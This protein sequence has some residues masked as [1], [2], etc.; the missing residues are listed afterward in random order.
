MQLQHHWHRLRTTDKTMVSIGVMVADR[1]L[2]LQGM[3]AQRTAIPIFGSA[4]GIPIDTAEF[5]ASRSSQLV[6]YAFS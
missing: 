5:P 3:T 4:L 1:I 6:H 2:T